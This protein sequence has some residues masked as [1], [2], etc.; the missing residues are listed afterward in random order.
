MFCSSYFFKI[1]ICQKDL[2]KDRSCLK[3]S[4]YKITLFSPIYHTKKF[5]FLQKVITS[6]FST[7]HSGFTAINTL[8]ALFIFF[9]AVR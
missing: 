2:S 4:D 3:G 9:I 5:F 1:V 7:L 6:V 8:F